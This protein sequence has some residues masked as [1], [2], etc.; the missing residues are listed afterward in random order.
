M[1]LANQKQRPPVWFS[2][3]LLLLAALTC[4]P[5]LKAQ[6]APVPA[7]RQSREAPGKRQ[8]TPEQVPA[9]AESP[10]NRPIKDKWAI[11]VGVSKFARP[12]LN[13]RNA[14]KDARD[15]YD[16][17]VKEA[18]F[19]PDHV[20]LLINEAATRR[21][22]LSELGSK[23]L[24][25]LAHP[26]DLVVI[27]ISS[28]GSASEMDVGGVNYLVVH[29]TDPDD[30][31]TTGID[32]QQLTRLIKSRVHCQRIVIILDAC[33]SGATR[34]SAK[35]LVRTGNIDAQ[36]VAMGTGQ[37]VIASSEPTQSSWEFK[38]KPNGVFTACLL[39]ALRAQ[40]KI[41]L[42]KA[43]NSTK[44]EVETVVL[45]ERGVLQSPVLK[46][47]WQGNDIIL[48][49]LPTD[50]RP[51]V[52]GLENEGIEAEEPAT[53]KESRYI[54]P[55]KASDPNLVKELAP[56]VALLPFSEGSDLETGELDFD[57]LAVRLEELVRSGLSARLQDRLL[58]PYAIGA[59]LGK[60]NLG[61]GIWSPEVRRVMGK[62]F[63]AR[64]LVKVNLNDAHFQENGDCRVS[65]SLTVASGISGDYLTSRGINAKG[66]HCDG[67]KSAREAFLRNRV[68]PQYARALVAMIEEAIGSEK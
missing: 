25:R 46:S 38:D 65:V 36:A 21:R 35:G 15:F 34:A 27:F 7:P 20:K 19:A 10:A 29:D 58:S 3:A 51:A 63:N 8:K 68:L 61:G 26:D 24:P 53:A 14:D 64:Y 31:F 55:T 45:R 11:V 1:N 22:V 39:S 62:A 32:M 28:H 49:V 47:A 9:K 13:L 59:A 30:L 66:L 52:T 60:Y 48:S 43:F 67:D 40:D 2:T 6:A 57:G 54:N 42:D 44:E 37:L 23:W 4:M 33:H 5:V 17:L 18:N 16:Y 56:R 12:A 41:S 50:P